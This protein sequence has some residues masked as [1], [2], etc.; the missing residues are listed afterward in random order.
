MSGEGNVGYIEGEEADSLHVI[1][2]IWLRLGAR[3]DHNAKEDTEEHGVEDPDDEIE[4][5]ESGEK[6]TATGRWLR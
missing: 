2:G 1:I 6:E 4:A 5:V 3:V